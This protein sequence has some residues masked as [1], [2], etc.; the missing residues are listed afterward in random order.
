M[1]DKTIALAAVYQS[2]LIAHE[3]ANSGEI[4]DKFSWYAS[5]STLFKIDSS[6]TEDIFNNDLKGISLGLTTLIKAFGKDP[7]YINVLK[8]SLTMLSLEGKLNSRPDLMDLIVNGLNSSK[9]FK[10]NGDDFPPAMISKLAN[11]YS[12][13]V[14][15]LQP[16]VIIAGKPFHLKKQEVTEKIRATLLAGIRA[17]VLWRQLGGSQIQLI[18]KRKAYI[19]TA[20]EISKSL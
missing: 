20:K 18:F 14:S 17:A 2:A 19:T 8:Y 7:Y 9:I 11:I 5:L 15:Q 3:L 16:R 12:D 4:R 10:K 6:S 13:T 1:K